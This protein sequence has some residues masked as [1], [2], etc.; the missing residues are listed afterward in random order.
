MRASFRLKTGRFAVLAAV[1]F[2]TVLT[3]SGACAGAPAASTPAAASPSDPATDAP[4]PDIGHAL[5]TTSLPATQTSIVNAVSSSSQAE[6]SAMANGLSPSVTEVVATSLANAVLVRFSE[7]VHMR[8]DVWLETS[9]GATDNAQRA[10]SHTLV[11]PAGDLTGAVDVRS[12]AFGDGAGLRDITGN[13]A[14]T[15]FTST[16]WTIGRNTPSVADSTDTAVPSIEGITAEGNRWV[17]TFTKPVYVLGSVCLQTSVECEKTIDPPTPT[18]LSRHVL[19]EDAPDPT[20]LNTR[21]TVDSLEYVGTR[22]P[23]RGADAVEADMSFEQLVWRGF[24]RPITPTL[25]DCVYD[26]GNDSAVTAEQLET[27][28]ALDTGALTDAQRYEWYKFFDRLGPD[29]MDSCVTAWSEALDGDNAEK[30]NIGRYSESC[31]F[32]L[33]ASIYDS[34][35]GAFAAWKEAADL[36]DVP[37]LDLTLSERS[38]LRNQI[39]E[40]AGCREYY[41]Q[42]FS[43][44]WIPLPEA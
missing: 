8:G 22:H 32:N 9:E 23:I 11:F 4:A 20:S 36:L 41:P 39:G 15:T 25:S 33:R 24:P 44:R 37:F 29:L 31:L 17:V 5:S 16:S 3:L 42:L 10:G 27:I 43:A 19:F 2:L 14:E 12:I 35:I 7:V 38:V 26:A 18:A 13:D 21:V 28:V 34:E 40:V 6:N 1:L 30:R